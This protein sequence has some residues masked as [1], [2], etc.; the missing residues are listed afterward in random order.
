M[1]EATLKTVVQIGERQYVVCEKKI[2]RELAKAIMLKAI[3][4][5]AAALGVSVAFLDI[6]LRGKN[7]LIG[8]GYYIVSDFLG[9]AAIELERI[10]LVGKKTIRELQAE[11]AK[12]GLSIGMFA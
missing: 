6:N 1:Q 10:Y 5:P 9:V 12:Y 7:A 2:D 4:C 8:A 11:L 3:N